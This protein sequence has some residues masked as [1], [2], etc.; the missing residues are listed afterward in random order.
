MEKRNYE[1][2]AAG[3]PLKLTGVAVVFN[4]PAQTGNVTEIIAPESEP[5]FMLH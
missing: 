1:I 4:Q 2:R 5:G 3:E